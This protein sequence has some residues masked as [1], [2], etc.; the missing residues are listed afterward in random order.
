MAG[1]SAAPAGL[2]ARGSKNARNAVTGGRTPAFPARWFMASP[3]LPGV[4]ALLATVARELSRPHTCPQQR[5]AMTHRSPSSAPDVSLVSKTQP[6]PP[7]PRPPRDGRRRPSEWS[8]IAGYSH[9]G[10]KH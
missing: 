8:G 5:E 3:T 4:L 7:S 2:R 1:C 6:R 10:R 9:F